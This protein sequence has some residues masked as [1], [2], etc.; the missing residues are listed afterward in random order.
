MIIVF[1]LPKVTLGEDNFTGREMF[2]YGQLALCSALS[3]GSEFI[4]GLMKLWSQFF[5]VC[6]QNSLLTGFAG[7]KVFTNISLV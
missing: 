4:C 7:C 3:R 5:I 2:E 1:Y 6:V